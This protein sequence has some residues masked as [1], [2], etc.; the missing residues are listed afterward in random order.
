[1]V[2]VHDVVTTTVFTYYLSTAATTPVSNDQSTF[3]TCDTT[4]C[5]ASLVESV[6]VNLAV[7]VD[8]SQGEQAQDQTVVYELSATSQAYDPA[9][10]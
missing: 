6:G 5:N 3:T 1:M 7:N 10:G 4:T 9:V 2:T 8:A